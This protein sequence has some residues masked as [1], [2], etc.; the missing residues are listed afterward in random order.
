[1][2]HIW[3]VDHPEDP[4]AEAPPPSVVTVTTPWDDTGGSLGAAAMLLDWPALLGEIGDLLA[5]SPNEVA[6]RMEAGKSWAEMAVAQGVSRA[7]LEQAVAE[8]FTRDYDRAVANGDMTSAQRDL[9]VRVLPEIIGRIVE[10]HR[11]EPWIV[12][13]AA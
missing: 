13:A 5:L 6:L 12:T 1:M 3:L 8:Q 10:L 9:L 4:F 11:G 2:L 7:D